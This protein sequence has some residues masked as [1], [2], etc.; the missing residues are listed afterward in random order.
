MVRTINASNVESKWNFQEKWK[1]FPKAETMSS[2]CDWELPL[3]VDSETF[4]MNLKQDQPFCGRHI[5]FKYIKKGLC[6]RCTTSGFRRCRYLY[7]TYG[8]M[9]NE[10]YI[11]SDS[12]STI[13]PW[14][15][16]RDPSFWKKA[17]PNAEW[18]DF[19]DHTDNNIFVYGTINCQNRRCVIKKKRGCRPGECSVYV[20]NDT[21][22]LVSCSDGCHVGRRLRRE[23]SEDDYYYDYSTAPRF[24]PNI[25]IGG[26]YN[27]APGL[28][29]GP[30]IGH[31]SGHNPAPHLGDGPNIGR[32]SGH[33]AAPHLGDGPNIGRGSGHNAAPRLG[34][35]PN[36]WGKRLDVVDE[37]DESVWGLNWD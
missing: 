3:Q 32:G 29:D 4:H 12:R 35:G 6:P 27:P 37:E 36:I 19:S 5:S 11:V 1:T 23:D 2:A 24:G 10:R 30:S 20:D 14:H 25:G 33:N 21:G 13:C 15:R 31:G 28:G 26:R 22:M 17:C 7:C 9:A 34:D 8:D 16:N 18:E